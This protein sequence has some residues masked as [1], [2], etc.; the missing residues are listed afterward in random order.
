MAACGYCNS[1]IIFG[2]KREGSLRFCNDKCLH[3]GRLIQASQQIPESTVLAL[4][5][6]LHGGTC[7]KC[8][9][10]GPVDVFKSYRVWSALLIT[11]WKNIPQVSCKRCGT[12][13]QWQSLGFSLLFG[14]WGFPWGLVMTPV[15]VGRNIFGLLRHY[16]PYRP[17][18]EL[19]RIARLQLANRRQA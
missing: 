13:S 9:G 7:P 2:G 5:Q 18:P 15:Q 19:E 12:M 3:A 16:D 6:T 10:S 17:S 4:V 14:W 8:H 11:S 1:T